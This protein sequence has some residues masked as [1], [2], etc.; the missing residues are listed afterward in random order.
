[1]RKYEDRVRPSVVL[2]RIIIVVAVL[3]AVPVAL[4]TVTAFVR[5]YVAPP[6]L[7][8]FASSRQM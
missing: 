6:K 1:M 3:T 5:A 4:W 8:L 2:R 7:L